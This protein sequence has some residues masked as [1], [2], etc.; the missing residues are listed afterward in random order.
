VD[1]ER[2]KPLV[3]A[4]I[5][6]HLPDGKEVTA[7][8]FVFYAAIFEP[9]SAHDDLSGLAYLA[10]KDMHRL[11][12]KYGELSSDALIND[13]QGGNWANYGKIWGPIH[14]AALARVKE[15]GL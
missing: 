8:V 15:L 2:L 6:G 11:V 5:I 14:A 4:E 9:V 12:E 7:S 13:E 3:H 10:D 1:E